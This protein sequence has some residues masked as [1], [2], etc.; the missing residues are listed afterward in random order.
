MKYVHYLCILVLL[1]LSASV[2]WFSVSCIQDFLQ[3]C[4]LP[5]TSFAEPW[6]ILLPDKLQWLPC[7][8]VARP[9]ALPFHCPPLQPHWTDLAGPKGIYSIGIHIKASGMA[10]FGRKLY[11]SIIPFLVPVLGS[12]WICPIPTCVFCVKSVCMSNMICVEGW[13][14]SL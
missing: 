6:P 8:L 4:E 11:T 9:A 7:F 2:K 13:N 12:Q 14:E 10:G 1:L 3:Y 5:L